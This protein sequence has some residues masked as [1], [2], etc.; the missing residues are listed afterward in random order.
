MFDPKDIYHPREFR[1]G[2]RSDL[3]YSAGERPSYHEPKRR[4]SYDSYAREKQAS[5]HWL[6]PAWFFFLGFMTAMFIAYRWPLLF[7]HVLTEFGHFFMRVGGA[8]SSLFSS[9]L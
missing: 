3:G 4:D 5:R 2:E 1:D 7:V 8:I 9:S 6:F